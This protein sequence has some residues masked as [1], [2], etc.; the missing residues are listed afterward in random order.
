M[1]R[2]LLVFAKEPRPGATKTR[3]VPP[4]TP[5]EASSIA[6]AFL[7][8]LAARLARVP[9]L[10]LA[11]ALPPEADPAAVRALCPFV[12]RWVSQGEG[13]LGDRMARVMHAEFARGASAVGV[14]GSDHP[15]LP[16]VYMEACFLAAGRGR[17]GWVTTEDGGYAAMVLPHPAPRMFEEVPWGT[18][19]VAAATRQRAREIALP[20]DDAGHWYDVDR[21]QD[22]VRLT[23]D[24]ELD[25]E[26][27]PH[28]LALLRQWRLDFENRGILPRATNAERNSS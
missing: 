5:E 18:A 23:R 7:T 12:S 20:L 28:T 6:T 15:N 8:D 2:S 10:D 26:V 19:Q 13:S 14:V 3:L 21:A 1:S 17:A 11:V 16:G 27:C 22:L 25:P 4:L 9:E 24:L